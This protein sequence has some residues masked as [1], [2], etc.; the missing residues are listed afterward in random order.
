[1]ATGPRGG[2]KVE[3][4]IIFSALFSEELELRTVFE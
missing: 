4:S 1:M 2:T 3:Q